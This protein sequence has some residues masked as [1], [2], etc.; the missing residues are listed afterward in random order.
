MSPFYHTTFQKAT[1]CIKNYHRILPQNM[2]TQFSRCATLI[3]AK[4]QL[5]PG[6][7]QLHS[8]QRK[9]KEQCFFV[10][11]FHNNYYPCSYSSA[12]CSLCIRYPHFLFCNKRSQ[13]WKSY[14]AKKYCRTETV[15]LQKMQWQVSTSSICFLVFCKNSKKT[16]IGDALSS[17]LYCTSQLYMV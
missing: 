10:Y 9:R 3:I 15:H 2:L 16:S 7:I 5:Y 4:R 1:I 14:R 13:R 8:E 17:I 6:K 11:K 12:S